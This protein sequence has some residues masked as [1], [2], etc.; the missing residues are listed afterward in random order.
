[1]RFRAF[2][3]MLSL[4][5]LSAFSAPV[6]T[7]ATTPGWECIPTTAGQAVISGG[8]GATPSCAAGTTAV[9]A[10]TF[11]SSGVGGKPTVQFSTV[12]VQVIDGTGSESTLNGTGNLIVGYDEK[13]GIQTG[14]HNL[15][16]GGSNS[17][18]SYGGIVAGL[19]NSIA[20]AYASVL[21]GSSNN[22]SGANSSVLGGFANKASANSASIVGGCSNFAGSGS[23]TVNASC[24]NASEHPFGYLAVLGGIGNQVEATAAT[25]AGGEKNTA[26]NTAASILGGDGNSTAANCQAIPAAPGTC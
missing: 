9:L 22:A 20:N 14:S 7:A 21:G 18:S 5:V 1:M 23:F 3:A 2:A 26:R 15:L 11:V 25:V 17:Y 12:N 8:T 19:T 24:L 10:P 6:A 4:P 16:L 13:P